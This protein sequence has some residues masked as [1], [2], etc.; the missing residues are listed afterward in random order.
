MGTTHQSFKNV[1]MKSQ[2]VWSSPGSSFALGSKYCMRMSVSGTHCNTMRNRHFI[3]N[4][5]HCNLIIYPH[6]VLIS[7]HKTA[8]LTIF[9]M[10]N[11]VSDGI[12]ETQLCI[13][14]WQTNL[15]PICQWKKN[16]SPYFSQLKI[17]KSVIF[18]WVKIV[19]ARV[20]C[21]LIW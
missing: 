19:G 6:L 9:S 21:V 5:L 11:R 12:S 3:V 4:A 8:H 13:C 18:T 17:G 16:K 2:P 1:K 10:M 20:Q 15:G 7:S 14:T